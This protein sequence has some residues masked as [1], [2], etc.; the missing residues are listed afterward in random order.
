MRPMRP[1]ISSVVCAMDGVAL[2]HA[3]ATINVPMIRCVI[4]SS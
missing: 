1:G 3:V 4:A 2:A